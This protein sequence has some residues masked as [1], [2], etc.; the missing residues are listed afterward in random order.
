MVLFKRLSHIL[1]LN[2]VA[3]L[4]FTCTGL[5]LKARDLSDHCRGGG[6]GYGAPRHPRDVQ[7]D[8][9]HL[10]Q[11]WAVSDVLSALRYYHDIRGDHPLCPVQGA[12]REGLQ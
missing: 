5:C 2:V 7:D 12:E 9:S 1:A 3:A 8:C 4:K 6:G 10:H 11:H